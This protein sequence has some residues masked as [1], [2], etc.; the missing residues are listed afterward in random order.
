VRP[1]F[2]PKG[3]QNEGFT[4]QMVGMRDFERSAKPDAQGRGLSKLE[5]V[6]R[7]S[8]VDLFFHKVVLKEPCCHKTDL[9]AKSMLSVSNQLL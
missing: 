8:Y 2:R 9:F 3:E 7:N 1:T 6:I 4:S 5:L